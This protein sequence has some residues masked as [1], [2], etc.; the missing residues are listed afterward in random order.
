MIE[1]NFDEANLDIGGRK[2][3]VPI[4]DILAS[5]IR[6]WKALAIA[7]AIPVVLS[8]AVAVTLP[9]I[10]D[11]EAHL[12]V[13]PDRQYT[14]QPL[15]RDDNAPQPGIDSEQIS[16]IEVEILGSR[17]LKL[18]VAAQLGPHAVD[19]SLP[20]VTQKDLLYD[21]A[22]NVAA[23]RL[24]QAID[25]ESEIDSS[26][27]RVRFSSR[28]PDIATAGLNR[29]VNDY[30]AYRQDI[31]NRDRVPFLLDKRNEASTRLEKARAD[32]A[33]F[34]QAHDIVALKDQVALLLDEQSRVNLSA[35][36]AHETVAERAAAASA[37]A[38]VSAQLPEKVVL[39]DDRDV[40]T[41]S[42]NSRSILLGLQLRRQELLSKY[43]DTSHYITDIDQ[44]IAALKSFESKNDMR[45]GRNTATGINPVVEEVKDDVRSFEQ[46]RAGNEAK[47][48]EMERQSQKLE[49]R[50]LELTSLRLEHRQ[51]ERAVELADQQYR[52]LLKHYDDALVAEAVD[53]HSIANVRVIETQNPIHARSSRRLVVGLGLL[54]GLLAAIVTAFVGSAFRE[55]MLTPSAAARR[56][57]LPVLARV[58]N[59]D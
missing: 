37:L 39:T 20:D 31:F 2:F 49:Q 12:L 8:L 36:Q 50:L 11:S 18:A 41:E 54:S 29:L 13:L 14:E 30:L 4:R 45:P 35:L 48:Q 24:E 15:T 32:L 33:A 26:I 22:V 27:I 59:R 58:A 46:D 57:G 44:Q 25:V 7:F 40:E 52:I 55:T 9:K 19:R 10:Y 43:A 28:D 53:K 56:L 38:A 5:L 1:E 34:N 16:K 21:R 17:E 3:V 6:G 42:G 23:D 47:G 51:L